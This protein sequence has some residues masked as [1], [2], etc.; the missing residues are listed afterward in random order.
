MQKPRQQVC[1][2]CEKTFTH[3]QYKQTYCSHECAQKAQQKRVQITCEQCGIV[4]EVK[5]YRVS[6]A[7]FCSLSC[8]GKHS[9]SQRKM[10]NPNLKGNQHAKGNISPTVFTSERVRGSNNPRWVEPVVKQCVNCGKEFTRKPW[11][12]KRPGVK[13]LFCCPKCRYAYLVGDKNPLWQG[14]EVTYRGKG[15]KELR[16]VVV[17]RQNGDCANCGKHV[18]RSLPVHH[19]KPFRL[20]RSTAEANQV[21]N[22]IGLC[23]SCH[24]KL[25][26]RKTS[27]A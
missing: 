1:P 12:L 25:E 7:R 24:M 2:V 23:Q 13:A 27:E 21:D 14:G 15:W 8:H 3:T 22:L 26:V 17:K 19:I 18:G 5:A 16:M 6:E 9:M 11:Q 4:F 20:F 10:T